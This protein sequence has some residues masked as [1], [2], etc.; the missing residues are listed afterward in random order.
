MTDIYTAARMAL[1]ALKRD[2]DTCLLEDT[3]RVIVA[4]EAALAEKPEPVAWAV[5]NKTTGHIYEV[6]DIYQRAVNLTGAREHIDGYR[7][8]KIV[9]VYFSPEHGGGK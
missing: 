1:D 6:T 4:L 9:P 2:E 3:E 7:N 8:C 5:V